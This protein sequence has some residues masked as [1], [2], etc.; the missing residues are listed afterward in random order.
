M[1]EAK[2]FFDFFTRYKPNEDVRKILELAENVSVRVAKTPLRIEVAARFPYVLGNG[3]LYSIE[4]ELRLMYSAESFRILPSFPPEAFSLASVA[5]IVDEAIRVGAIAR[6]FLN[7][8]TYADDGQAITVSVP[9]MENAIAFMESASTTD[10]LAAITKSRFGIDRRYV[11]VPMENA[12]ELTEGRRADYDRVIAEADARALAEFREMMSA[13]EGTGEDPYADFAFQSKLEP[14]ENEALSV[15]G[16]T[17]RVGNSVF[18]F[19]E[20]ESVLG[21]PF[22]IEKAVSMSECPLR[23]MLLFWLERYLRLRQRTIGTRPESI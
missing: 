14:G 5:D 6:G 9:F 12:Q 1:P 23:E 19:S 20:S 10:I 13:S 2:R 8:A 3:F 16:T 18:D 21:D 4:E 11:I 22:E 7:G 15:T 17:V